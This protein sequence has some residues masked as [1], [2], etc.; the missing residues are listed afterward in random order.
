MSIRELRARM[1]A[2]WRSARELPLLGPAVRAADRVW[3]VRAISR[4]GLVDSEFYAAQR[5]VRALTEHRAVWHYVARGFR[6][7]LSLNPLFDEVFAGGKLPEVFRVPA[8]YAYALSDRPTVEVHPWWRAVEHGRHL[9]ATGVT[10]PALEHVWGARDTAEIDLTIDANVV[11]VP[12]RQFRE[13]ALEAARAWARRDFSEQGA[14]RPP[15][16]VE[17]SVL[18][19]IQVNDRR[20][21]RLL[22][23]G[24]RLAHSDAAH[25]VVLALVGPNASQWITSSIL[26]RIDP[27]VRVIG[28]PASTRWAELVSACAA[29]VAGETLVIV[30]PRIA[31]DD[32]EIDALA[33]IARGGAA[34]IP[35]VR[36]FDGTLVGVGAAHVGAG[37]P[38]RILGDHPQEDIDAFGAEPVSV[39]LLTGRTIALPT[40]LLADA[41]PWRAGDGSDGEL[42]TLSAELRRRHPHIELLVLPELRP[43]QEEPEVAFVSRGARRRRAVPSEG[44]PVDT[45]RAVELIGRAGFTVHGWVRRRGRRPVPRLRWQRPT[46]QCQRWAI[47]ICAPAGPRGAVWGDTHFALGLARALRRRGHFVVVDAFDARARS[48][49]YLDDVSVVV[50]GPY[51]IDAPRHGVALQWIIS[52]PDEIKKAE[53]V[54]F[55]RVFAASTSWSAAATARWGI[56]VAPLLECTDTDQFFPRALPRG[57]DIVFVG[58]ARGIA[59]PSVVAPLRAG[60]PV[61]VYGP[62][63][64]PFIP[65]TAIVA[66]SIP[67][68][69]LPAR[70]ETASIVLNDQ[71]P[72]MRR[73]GFIAMRPFDAVAVG[74]RVISESIEGIREIFGP[75][76]VTYDDEEELLALLARRPDELFP[77]DDELAV[78]AERIRREHS[79]DARAAVLAA[80]ADAA[81]ADRTGT[82]R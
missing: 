28:R 80:A 56:P 21:A 31:I 61:K 12:V 82:R 43:V 26:S 63:W 2:V 11:R 77:G 71:W 6:Q 44:F 58:T 10:A 17:I 5:G 27:A 34:V 41:G 1:R 79:F 32:D 39:P 49:A 74:G 55:S 18:R 36:A 54:A 60:V 14:R 65:A 53:I 40:R 24:A 29:E 69:E 15:E 38:Y 50:R 37:L 66:T 81:R 22:E 46:A 68:T 13:W 42:E 73:E 16:G 7:G 64:R 57:D 51:R 4:S 52:H 78:I 70:Y 45:T 47:K 67:N 76:V 23:Q 19:M 75:A 62:D 30:D 8:L 20:Y 72:A 59:R 35:A 48:T 3:W 9:A 33:A 25:Q